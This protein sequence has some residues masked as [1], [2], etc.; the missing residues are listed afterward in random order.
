M[1]FIILQALA[2]QTCFCLR[3]MD[4]NEIQ[5]F[6]RIIN[7]YIECNVFAANRLPVY[8][9]LPICIIS[10]LDPDTKPG[11]HWVAIH[12]DNNGVGEYFDSFGRKPIEHHK[13][14]LKRN[15]KIWVYN[16]KHLQN[17]FTSI[18]GEYCLVYLYF[19]YKKMFTMKQF[20]NFFSTNTLCNDLLLDEMFNSIFK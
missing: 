18:C 3:N 12:V 15:A 4:T 7:P 10:N 6:M 9:S 2:L 17:Y 20:I 14:F 13:K 19:R 5:N 8:S 1:C 11:S 16:N